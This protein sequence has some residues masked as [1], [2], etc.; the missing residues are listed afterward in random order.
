LLAN[1]NA[2]N[3]V[4]QPSLGRVLSGGLSNVPVNLIEPGTL[5]GDRMNTVDMRFGK[6]LRFNRSRVSVAMDL[7]NLFNASTVLIENSA[8]SPT[9]TSWRTPQTV[10][11]PRLLKFSAQ[12]DF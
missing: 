4:T 3:A 11:A 5:Y 6:L 7:Y 9:T 8:Y 10:I 12:F 1:Y 2:P